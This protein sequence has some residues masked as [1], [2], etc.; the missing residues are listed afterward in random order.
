MIASRLSFVFNNF[1]ASFLEFWTFSGSY[2]PFQ[3]ARQVPL[4]TVRH[5]YPVATGIPNSEFWDVV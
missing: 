3:D 5:K 1:L 2:S 4:P